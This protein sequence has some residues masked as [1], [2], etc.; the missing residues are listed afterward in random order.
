MLSTQKWT[1]RLRKKETER[2]KNNFKHFNSYLPSSST[3][4][5]YAI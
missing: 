5:P 2:E 4:E 3:D 1:E